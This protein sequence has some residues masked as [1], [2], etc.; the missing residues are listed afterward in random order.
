MEF[1]IDVIFSST[2]FRNLSKK[3]LFRL[4][5]NANAPRRI[6]GKNS[7]PNFADYLIS[8]SMNLRYL[9]KASSF[10]FTIESHGS[11]FNKTCRYRLIST[12]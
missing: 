7:H 8:I 5:I 2:L 9:P 6:I 11:A 4:L 10:R 1:S 3:L 12:H